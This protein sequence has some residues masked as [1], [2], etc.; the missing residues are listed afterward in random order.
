MACRNS[1]AQV[2]CPV[3]LP[4][5]NPSAFLHAHIDSLDMTADKEDQVECETEEGGLASEREGQGQGQGCSTIMADTKCGIMY[6]VL[7]AGKPDTFHQLSAARTA[8]KGQLTRNGLLYRL[9]LLGKQAAAATG[10]DAPG[11]VLPS[12]LIPAGSFNSGYINI[13]S[14]PKPLG[15]SIKRCHPDMRLIKEALS[16]PSLTLSSS[17]FQVAD[18]V[19]LPCVTSSAVILHED[20]S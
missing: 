10:L 8:V 1:G 13:E 4:G 9:N 15:E 2:F 20:S 6:L 16:T 7:L 12:G 14:L 5:F 3:C 11:L 19:P 17:Y 18:L